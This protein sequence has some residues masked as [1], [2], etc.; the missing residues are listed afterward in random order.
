MVGIC[1][2]AINKGEV[3]TPR[4]EKSTPIIPA[5]YSLFTRA[6]TPKIKAIGLNKKDSINIPINPK[7]ILRLP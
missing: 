7:I 6:S 1:I 3:K 5:I 4:I 2:S